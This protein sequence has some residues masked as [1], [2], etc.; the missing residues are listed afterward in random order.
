M[1]LKFGYAWS[2]IWSVESNW[3]W[4]KYEM[5]SMGQKLDYFQLIFN[6]DLPYQTMSKHRQIWHTNTLRCS[7][8]FSCLDQSLIP[9]LG[10][11]N[12]Q[13]IFIMHE[14]PKVHEQSTRACTDEFGRALM[15][16]GSILGT[17]VRYTGVHWVMLLVYF[18]EFFSSQL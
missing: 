3:N 15:S 2:D 8:Q 4:P 1:Y 17:R 11:L 12:L 5:I 6:V 13:I 7:L 14:P 18:P 16:R 10:C 9:M